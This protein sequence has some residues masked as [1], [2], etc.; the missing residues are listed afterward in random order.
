MKKEI[1][2][3]ICLAFGA[4]VLGVVTVLMVG[5]FFILPNLAN[6]MAKFA[7]ET[8]CD[9]YVLGYEDGVNGTNDNYEKYN[10]EDS[11]NQVKDWEYKYISK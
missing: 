4:F 3:K 9:A 2:K 1:I 5:W 6:D 7:I 11:Y 8:G 10:F